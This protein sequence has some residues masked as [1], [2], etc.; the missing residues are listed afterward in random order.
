MTLVA[1]A[2]SHKA[3]WTWNNATVSL[4]VWQ[5]V[6]YCRMR[7]QEIFYHCTVLVPISHGLSKPLL[8]ADTFL[9]QKPSMDFLILKYGNSVYWQ[10][11]FSESVPHCWRWFYSES[12]LPLV[13][14]S[15]P[16]QQSFASSD[17]RPL[18]IPGLV[19]SWVSY[20]QFSR[21]ATNRVYWTIDTVTN[22]RNAFNR[23]FLNHLS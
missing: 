14:S 12:R 13:F 18:S 2:G 11:H 15:E 22:Q 20:A 23:I 3:R 9:F 5:V 4:E 10:I 6:P 16:S 21:T 1:I 19:E 8:A 17:D 7:S